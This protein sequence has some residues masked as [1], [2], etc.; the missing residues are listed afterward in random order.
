METLIQDFNTFSKVT[1]DD[2][3]KEKG[4]TIL[5][6]ENF[7]TNFRF[8]KRFNKLLVT[9][10]LNNTREE[11]YL[12]DWSV[13]DLLNYIHSLEP[14]IDVS[15]YKEHSESIL[16]ISAMFLADFDTE[17]TVKYHIASRPSYLT[18]VLNYTDLFNSDYKFKSLEVLS[19]FG[20]PLEYFIKDNNLFLTNRVWSGDLYITY[21]V[22]KLHIRCL[23]EFV[24]SNLSQLYTFNE[25]LSI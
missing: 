10:Y 20:T 17:K 4:Y 2:Y 8:E 14:G 21:T 9:D 11:I 1:Y 25:V 19:S 15:R 18:P 16:S 24:V 7:T 6:I 13:Y 12:E 5:S 23:S 3:V 22:E